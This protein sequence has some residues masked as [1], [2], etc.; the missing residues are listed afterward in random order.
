MSV[1]I[2]PHPRNSP[3]YW[4]GKSL[5][6]V[7]RNGQPIPVPF[8]ERI[9]GSQLTPIELVK[10][11]DPYN[12]G[13]K[14]LCRCECGNET[15]GYASQIMSLHKKSCGCLARRSRKKVTVV[16]KKIKKIKV[17][18]KPNVVRD[19]TFVEYP[20]GR[21]VKLYVD[22]GEVISDTHPEWESTYQYSESKAVQTENLRKLND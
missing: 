9:K 1:S 7:E 13:R 14:V 20:N 8:G 16:P 11:D 6:N 10:N 21:I 2:N 5:R 17:L 3:R 12:S 18:K 22:N 19:T 15:V 4:C